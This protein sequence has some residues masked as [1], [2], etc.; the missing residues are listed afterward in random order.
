MEVIAYDCLE[1]SN[2]TPMLLDDYSKIFPLGY[3]KAH[4][5]TLLVRCIPFQKYIQIQLLKKS[6]KVCNMTSKQMRE[7]SLF[8]RNS[9][10]TTGKWEYPM[11]RKQEI[12]LDDVEGLPPYMEIEIALDNGQEYDEAQ[13]E[14]FRLF[15][16]LGIT[17]G[18]ERTSYMELLEKLL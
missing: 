9:F 10:E 8:T 15:E 6:R 4:H 18:F 16:K 11:I 13:S 3:A 1:T 2:N 17:D 7:D 14:I 5:L 12:S